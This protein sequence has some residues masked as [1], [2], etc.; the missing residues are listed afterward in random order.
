M[1]AG[2][3]KAKLSQVDRDQEVTKTIPVGPPEEVEADPIV[4]SREESAVIED[5]TRTS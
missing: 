2:C 5:R 3:C 1:G 4:S